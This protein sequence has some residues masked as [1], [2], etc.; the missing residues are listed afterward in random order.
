MTRLPGIIDPDPGADETVKNVKSV[1]S[2]IYPS[3]HFTSPNNLCLWGSGLTWLLLSISCEAANPFLWYLP[4]LR[5]I[6]ALSS[7]ISH[8][9]SE[10][11]VIFQRFEH[12]GHRLGTIMLTE[13]FYSYAQ[14]N[15]E[16]RIIHVESYIVINLLF[17]SLCDLSEANRPPIRCGKVRISILIND[18]QN[19]RLRHSFFLSLGFWSICLPFPT[20]Q[21][22]PWTTYY[23][24]FL[25]AVQLYWFWANLK[26]PW[27][28]CDHCCCRRVMR[29]FICSH[30]N[31]AEHLS[32]IIV[33]CCITFKGALKVPCLTCKVRLWTHDAMF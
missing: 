1:W 11:D 19:D 24:Q 12:A 16:Y 10:L 29:L 17:C 23:F 30:G 25:S 32:A 22:L 8:L 4:Y 6:S 3:E 27:I 31:S 21:M 13:S 9:F 14:W 20:V 18:L 15:L 28:V 33:M 5:L 7:L 2:G 26:A